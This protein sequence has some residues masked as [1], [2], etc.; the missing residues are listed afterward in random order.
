MSPNDT[1]SQRLVAVVQTL[2]S[3]RKSS[4]NSHL[5]PWTSFTRFAVA[6]AFLWE[7]VSRFTPCEITTDS[8][9]E[10]DWVL[11]GVVATAGNQTFTFKLR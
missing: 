9:E 8:N 2:F 3:G 6:I 11:R 4:M 7:W 10:N 5:P 1:A